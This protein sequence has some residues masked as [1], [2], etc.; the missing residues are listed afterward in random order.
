MSRLKNHND[1]TAVGVV[2][3]VAKVWASQKEACLFMGCSLE[4]LRDNV[5]H[6]GEVQ[7]AR[8]GGMTWYL[9]EDL[10]KFIQNRNVLK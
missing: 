5:L 1:G 7:V 9:I 8:H 3:P 6:S 2:Q 4:W 10:N